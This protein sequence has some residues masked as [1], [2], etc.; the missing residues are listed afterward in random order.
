MPFQLPIFC[1]KLSFD[2]IFVAETIFE[3]V[4]LSHSLNE[5]IMPKAQI[6]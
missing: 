2:L 1:F 5:R 6:H 4:F 3:P